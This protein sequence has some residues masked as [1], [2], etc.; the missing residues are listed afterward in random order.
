MRK[1]DDIGFSL[2]CRVIHKK[3]LQRDLVLVD[4]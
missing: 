2:L 4:I 3:I 1:T